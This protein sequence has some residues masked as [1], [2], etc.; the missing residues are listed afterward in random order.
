[1]AMT[2]LSHLLLHNKKEMNVYGLIIEKV[3]FDHLT[4][5]TAPFQPINL[6][7]CGVQSRFQACTSAKGDSNVLEYM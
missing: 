1:M 2:S 6:L 7:L 4:F 3:S 5:S